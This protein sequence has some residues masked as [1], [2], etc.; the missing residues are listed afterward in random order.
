MGRTADLE[1]DTLLDSIPCTANRP[2]QVEELPGGL[3]NRNLK[4][5]MPDDTV[6]VRIPAPGPGLLRINRDQEH[7]NSVA[8]ATAGVGPPVLHYRPGAGLT[9]RYL[10]SRT[11]T[12]S[13]LHDPAMLERVALACKQL[14][15][16]PR[17][18]NEFDMFVLQA[19]YRDIVAKHGFRLPRATASSL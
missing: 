12:D 2:R 13:D 5:I 7:A 9:V 11:L 18:V 6:V 10:D 3:T 1:I 8:A 14:H 19:R 16:G 15:A 17:F 4:V